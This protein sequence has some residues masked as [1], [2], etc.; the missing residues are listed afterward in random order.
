MRLPIDKKASLEDSRRR[1]MNKNNGLGSGRRHFLYCI[2]LSLRCTLDVNVHLALGLAEQL[3]SLEAMLDWKLLRN[4]ASEMEQRDGQGYTLAIAMYGNAVRDTQP[5]H[6]S[7][8]LLGHPVA[9][10][11]VADGQAQFGQG[12][13]V[14]IMK[15]PVERRLGSL[16]GN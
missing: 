16:Y 1:W 11:V 12:D 2:D 10:D 5:L 13:I 7:V 4:L 8:D 6:P 14:A 15:K 3:A 9:R